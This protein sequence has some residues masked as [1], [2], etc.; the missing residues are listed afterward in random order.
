MF[1]DYKIEDW[2]LQTIEL[3]QCGMCGLFTDTR[4][5]RK[6]RIHL[7]YACRFLDFHIKVKW[8]EV[9]SRNAKV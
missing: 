9:L 2:D 8:S 6:Q 4:W 3:K 1:F 7:C 5:H